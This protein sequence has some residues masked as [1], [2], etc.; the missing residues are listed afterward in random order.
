[1]GNR[2]TGWNTCVGWCLGDVFRVYPGCPLQPKDT[3]TLEKG[4]TEIQV[5][6]HLLSVMDL[7]WVWGVHGSQVHTQDGMD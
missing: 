6:G 4:I 3:R 5:R 7:S 2:D 1:M